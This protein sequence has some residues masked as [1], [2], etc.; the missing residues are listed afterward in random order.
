MTPI[1]NVKKRT[2]TPSNRHSSNNNQQ[3]TSIMALPTTKRPNAI[4]ILTNRYVFTALVFFVW[5]LLIDGN[6][7][8]S[9]LRIRNQIEEMKEKEDYYKNEIKLVNQSL[10][11][12]DNKATIEK[13]ARETYLMKRPNEDIYVVEEKK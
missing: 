9:Q 5:M 11:E 6:N 4:G 8:F 7:L 13:F 1:I 12:L 2:F 10:K 3:L